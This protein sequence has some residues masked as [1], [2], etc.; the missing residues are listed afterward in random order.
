MDQRLFFLLNMARH[1]VFHSV[2]AEAE[3]RL[4]I[5]VTQ[6]AALL[7]IAKQSG[8]LQKEL[9]L[10]LGLNKPAVSGLVGRMEKAGLI[11]KQQ[12]AADGRGWNLFLDA[13]GEEVLPKIP[14]LLD[15]LNSRLSEGFDQS[16]L[17]VICRFLNTTISRF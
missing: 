3:S 9:G 16:E 17:E 15:E 2:D 14:A 11:R 1:K 13:K 4:G 10:A 12:S 6:V 8:C 7:F 5:P